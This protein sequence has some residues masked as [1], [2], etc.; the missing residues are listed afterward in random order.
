MALRKVSTALF[1]ALTLLLVSASSAGQGIEILN[2]NLPS[3]YLAY[4]ESADR[5]KGKATVLLELHNNT[6]A[7]INVSANFRTE[8]APTIEDGRF[9]LSD[10][11]FGTFLKSGSE[12]ELCYDA[13][14]LFLQTGYAMPKKTPNPKITDLRNSC[15][16]RSNGKGIDDPYSIGYWI[17]SKEFV[18]F[19]LPEALLREGLKVYTEFRYPW[20]FTN[21]RVRLN[22][23]KHRV[24]FFYFDIPSSE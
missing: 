24:Y 21:S 18:R 23:P 1:A 9:E 10:G 12:V 7:S 2:K 8:S 15:S 17:R 4:K 13:E 11:S 16:Y 14:G 20:E 3:V 6:N 19:R 22:E 5:T